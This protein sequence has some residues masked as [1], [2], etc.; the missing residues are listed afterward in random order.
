MMSVISFIVESLICSGLF[1][2]L[3]RW[4]LA[5][6]VGFKI[7]RAYLIVTMVLSVTIPIMDVPLY[8][9]ENMVRLSEWTVFSFDD[10]GAVPADLEE[11]VAVNHNSE[12]IKPDSSAQ[13]TGKSIDLKL[14]LTILYTLVGA[15]SLALL[16]YNTAWIYRL[17]S[18]S[19]LTY[20]D[21]TKAMKLITTAFKELREEVSAEVFGKPLAEL[22]DTEMQVIYRAVPMNV[23]EMEPRDVP[24][25][26]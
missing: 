10:F 14:I 5:K 20:E 9:S 26:K 24:A 6:K 23:S 16:A 17:R 21:Y 19:K 22:S 25:R 2:V 13:I 1:L 18:K 11:A 3:Y 12:T 15:I 4:M 7:C 8:P